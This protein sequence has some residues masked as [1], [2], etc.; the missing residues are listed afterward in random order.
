MSKT[1]IFEYFMFKINKMYEEKDNYNCTFSEITRIQSKVIS[2]KKNNLEVFLNSKKL[3]IMSE[4]DNYNY[5]DELFIE[6]LEFINFK[7]EI[8]LNVETDEINFLTKS[9]LLIANINTL[10]D[11][12]GADRYL[13]LKKLFQILYSKYKEKEYNITIYSSTSFGFIKAYLQSI[14]ELPSGDEKLIKIDFLYLNDRVGYFSDRLSMKDLIN[15]VTKNDWL[16]TYILYEYGEE[17][18]DFVEDGNITDYESTEEGD[19]TEESYYYEDNLS[20]Y[21]NFI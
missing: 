5:L 9:C 18:D 11:L 2:N 10:D 4:S 7:N 19:T 17:D 8:Y 20:E 6:F 15:Y 3:V 16:E 12:S 21:D 13:R 14:D 1:T